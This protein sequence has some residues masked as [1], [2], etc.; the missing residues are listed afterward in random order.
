MTYGKVAYDDMVKSNS[1]QII[2][3]YE[4]TWRHEIEK[5]K[6]FSKTDKALAQIG[7]PAR[8]LNAHVDDFKPE[9]IEKLPD[10]IEP[11]GIFIFGSPSVGKTHL[12]AALVRRELQHHVIQGTE[13]KNQVMISGWWSNAHNIL[14]EIRN[15][16]GN[17]EG[18]SE[19]DLVKRYVSYDFLIIDDLGTEKQSEWALAII[20]NIIDNRMNM[21]R[22]TLITSNLS[23]KSWGELDTRIVARLSAYTVVKFAGEDKRKEKGR[24]VEF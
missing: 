1:P 3:C 13:H 4:C 18:H 15:T 21:D 19:L 10:K 2:H 11:P 23:V 5:L 12:A 6:E 22:T 9:R 16:F 8:F 14:A 24:M 20:C 17:K 7:V